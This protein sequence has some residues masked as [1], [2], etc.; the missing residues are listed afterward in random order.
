MNCEQ[1]RELL[2]GYIDGELKRHERSRVENHL[3]SC[4]SCKAELAAFRLLQ[5]RAQLSCARPS[6][7]LPQRVAAELSNSRPAIREVRNM[8]ARLSIAFGVIA[9]AA[10]AFVALRPTEAYAD[11]GKV[12]SA[13]KKANK[14]HAVATVKNGQKMVKQEVWTT[15]GDWRLEVAGEPAKIV[16]GGKMF[17]Q[18]EDDEVIFEMVDVQP[19]KTGVGANLTFELVGVLTKDELA[20]GNEAKL[21]EGQL[22][23]LDEEQSGFRIVGTEEIDGKLTQKAILHRSGDPYRTV[24]WLD[25]VTSLPVVAERQK[26]NGNIWDVISQVKYDFTKPIPPSMFDPKQR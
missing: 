26:K 21:I 20:K 23:T 9:L 3:A 19:S 2:N 7:S 10:V 13:L 24:L 22:L 16:K 6:E 1:A 12:K 4:K 17:V 25:P 15:E 5:E 18:N 8:K 14:M 11:L